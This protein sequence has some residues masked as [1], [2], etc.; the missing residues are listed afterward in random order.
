VSSIISGIA[1]YFLL[2][3]KTRQR[4]NDNTILE[5]KDAKGNHTITTLPLEI[6]DAYYLNLPV[7][8]KNYKFTGKKC[9]D[10]VCD[11]VILKNVKAINLFYDDSD[12]NFLSGKLEYSSE[13]PL[14][15]TKKT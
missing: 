3:K 1:A 4:G 8:S 2:S 5:Y 9:I 13:T 11:D 10:D 15:T 12:G 7:G 14:D 6:K